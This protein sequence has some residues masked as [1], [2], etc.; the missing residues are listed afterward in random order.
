MII[1]LTLG[2]QGKNIHLS[3]S[4]SLFSLSLSLSIYIYN[5]YDNIYRLTVI[6][7]LSMTALRRIVQ[8]GP[9]ALQISFSWCFGCL[10]SFIWDYSIHSSITWYTSWDTQSEVLYCFRKPIRCREYLKHVLWRSVK[11][12]LWWIVNYVLWWIVKCVPWWIVK[13]VPLRIWMSVM[14][15]NKK[16][17]KQY[18]FE[19]IALS[20]PMK[21]LPLT[22][23]V[24]PHIIWYW[25]EMTFS[26]EVHRSIHIAHEA[27][28]R[29]AKCRIK[30]L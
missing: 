27:A 19:A 26:G 17:H 29:T 14:H 1:S 6:L 25:K 30:L 7:T 11:Y 20:G 13:C 4:L 21:F 12:V 28:L 2:Y 24:E 16:A 10:F 15:I 22:G 18:L 9:H 5:I 8:T 3:F 23:N